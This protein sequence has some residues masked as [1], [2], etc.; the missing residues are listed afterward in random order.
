MSCRNIEEGELRVMGMTTESRPNGKTI[1]CIVCGH[2]N[3]HNLGYCEKCAAD[4]PTQDVKPAVTQQV[5]STCGQPNRVGTVWCEACGSNLKTGERPTIPTR[6]ISPE[7]AARLT[8]LFDLP[9]GDAKTLDIGK[10]SRTNKV[11]TSIF[12]TGTILRVYIEG[13]DTPLILR[14][15]PDRPVTFGRRDNTMGEVDIDLSPYGAFQRGISRRH[16][17]IEVSDKRLEIWDL[18][19]SNGTYLNGI[20]LEANHRQQLRD[21]DQIRLGQLTLQIVFQQKIER[22]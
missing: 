12:D 3:T 4:L 22:K 1:H 11:G 5:C 14:L 2:I 10:S 9:V 6:A 16:A 7:K 18:G 15:T 20:L 21:G 8:E 17:A 13:I 19:S